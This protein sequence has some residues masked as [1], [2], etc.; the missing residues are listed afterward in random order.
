MIFKQGGKDSTVCVSLFCFFFKDLPVFASLR[1]RT[2]CATP[3]PLS[4]GMRHLLYIKIDE[5]SAASPIGFLCSGSE[6]NVLS[7]IILAVPNHT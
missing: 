2:F 6:A 7:P 3:P 4:L 1:S 5:P